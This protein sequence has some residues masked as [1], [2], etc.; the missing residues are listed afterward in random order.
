M[1]ICLSIESHI[2]ELLIDAVGTTY[3]SSVLKDYFTNFMIFRSESV[4]SFHAT[5]Y[6]NTQCSVPLKTHYSDP[7]FVVFH[8]RK[9]WLFISTN[10][11]VCQFNHD[12]CTLSLFY[13]KL[14]FN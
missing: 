14:L 12:L 3:L 10:Q 5:N 2:Y 4:F 1:E 6:S 7:F 11:F 13:G 8:Y 9:N